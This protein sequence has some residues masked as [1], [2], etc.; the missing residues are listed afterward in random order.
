MPAQERR[1]AQRVK[2]NLAI[3]VSGGPEEAMGETLNISTNGVYFQS[4]NFIEPLTKVQLE[5]MIPVREEGG[6]EETS[7]ICDGIVVRVEPEHED[8]S[9]SLYNVAVFF[10]FLSDSSQKTLEKYITQRLSS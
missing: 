3:S 10:S 7:V 9:I 4:P 6:E 5:L 1:K 2:A 8:P